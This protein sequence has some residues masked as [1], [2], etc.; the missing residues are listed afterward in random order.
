[1]VEQGALAHTGLTA[2]DEGAT[3]LG[4]DELGQRGLFVVPA[5]HRRVK[6]FH[7]S[8]IPLIVTDPAAPAA[9]SKK[10]PLWLVT[11]LS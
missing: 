1:M 3:A 11:K 10:S 9:A 2:Q 4:G 7:R 8:P 5:D 6:R